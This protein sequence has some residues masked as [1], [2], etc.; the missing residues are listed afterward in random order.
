MARFGEDSLMK[1]WQH[2]IMMSDLP[3]CETNGKSPQC[4]HRMSS[5][6]L[7]TIFSSSFSYTSGR[8]RNFLHG[9]Y[10]MVT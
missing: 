5:F 3:S 8:A 7:L 2:I 6:V 1:I 4:L 9:T 10:W